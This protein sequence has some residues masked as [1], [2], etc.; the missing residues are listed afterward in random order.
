MPLWSFEGAHAHLTRFGGHSG[1]GTPLPIPN[2]EVK[3]ASAAGT[4]RATSRESRSPPNYLLEKPRESGAF[5]LHPKRAAAEQPAVVRACQIAE[6][7]P[8]QPH[9]RARSQDHA[10][11]VIAPGILE[12]EP[13]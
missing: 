2:R 3:P 7:R 9:V 13:R 11:T 8:D 1:G 4:R 5:L 10:A 12:L 6:S